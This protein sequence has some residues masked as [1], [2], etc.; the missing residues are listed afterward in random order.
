MFYTVRLL[1]QIIPALGLLVFVVMGC[2]SG[3]IFEPGGIVSGTSLDAAAP[4]IIITT[5]NSSPQPDTEIQFDV[6]TA[7]NVYVEITNATGYHI[8]TLMDV[9]VEAGTH[10]ILWDGT[11]DGGDNINPGI[12][13]VHLATSDYETWRPFGYA[14]MPNEPVWEY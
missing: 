8:R 11:N 12:Y 14:I 5:D 9:A 4:K 3:D 2:S 7:G 13:I 6:A 1:I 10:H